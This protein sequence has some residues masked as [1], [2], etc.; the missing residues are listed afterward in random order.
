MKN[1]ELPSWMLEQPAYEP[2]S[3]RDGFITK[4]I[5]KLMSLMIAVRDNAASKS[6]GAGAAMK[7]IATLALII[8][9]AMSRNMF[10]TWCL[11]AG[12]LVRLLFVPGPVLLRI[13]KSAFGVTLLSMLIL[14]PSVFLGSPRTMLTVSLKVFLSVGLISLMSLTMPWNEVTEALRIFHVPDMFIFIF[15]ITLKYIAILGDIACNMLTALKMRSVGRNRHKGHALSG[16]LGVTFLKSHEM[17]DEMYEAMA[18]RGFEGEYR[19]R[20]KN[21]F[22]LRDIPLALALAAAIALFIYLQ[23]AV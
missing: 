9:A 23:K 18:C 1:T 22:G 17:A 7:L 8:L 3:D 16:I 14:L 15:D 21:P 10:F 12:F 4:S 5:L 11:I 20:K 2:E 6:N 19:K 13:M